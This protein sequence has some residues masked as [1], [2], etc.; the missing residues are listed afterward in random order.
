VFEL[1]VSSRSSRANSFDWDKVLDQKP[2]ILTAGDGDD[3]DYAVGDDAA[4]MT[5]VREQ[6]KRRGQDVGIKAIVDGKVKTRTGEQ[7]FTSCPGS[8]IY[9]Q[10][11]SPPDKERGDFYLNVKTAYNLMG[12]LRRIHEAD[13][14]DEKKKAEFLASKTQHETILSE[15][16]E[17]YGS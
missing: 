7:V 12:R 6:A 8:G 11:L 16:N 13:Q 3:D 10:A 1:E 9:V 5:L 15:Y 4:M 14:K 2:H 17:L